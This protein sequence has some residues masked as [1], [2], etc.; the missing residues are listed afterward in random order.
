MIKK[1]KLKKQREEKC[2]ERIHNV[3]R[4]QN[5]KAS[6]YCCSI[7]FHYKSYAKVVLVYA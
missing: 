6:L 5:E 3:G 7:Y 2:Q 4:K 1:K